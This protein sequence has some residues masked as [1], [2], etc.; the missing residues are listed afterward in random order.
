MSTAARI[1][2]AFF[3]L[4]VS[5]SF[6]HGWSEEMRRELNTPAPD[7]LIVGARIKIDET[8][9]ATRM[10]QLIGQSVATLKAHEIASQ[11]QVEESRLRSITPSV[12]I[13]EAR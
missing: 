11:Y 8:K 4:V 2:P 9:Q 3:A 5:Q 6:G 12:G 7:W 1:A 13:E 10:S